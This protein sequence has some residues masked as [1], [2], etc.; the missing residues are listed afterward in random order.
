M[1]LTDLNLI[2]TWAVAVAQAIDATGLDSKAVF[3]QA[4]IDLASARDSSTRIPSDR[5]T[6]VY[7]L[8]EEVTD[9]P[10]FGLAIAEHIH[11]TS[12]H[13]LGY[14][15]FASRTLESFCRRIVRY[16]RLVTT[17]AE[18]ELQQT[19]NAYRLV[20]VP[21]VGR[22]AY[23]PQDAWLATV[24]RFTRETY[25]HDFAPRRVELR[26]PEPSKNIEKFTEFF[27]APIDFGSEANVLEIATEDMHAQLPAANPELAR[28]NDQLVLE[29]LARLDRDDIITQVRSELV[30]LLPSGDCTKE[31]V[32]AHLNM[33]ER[34]LQ[35]RLMDKGTSYRELLAEMRKELA[36]QYI[37][38]GLH[39]VSDVAYLLGFSEISSF[40][41]A[42]RTWTGVSAS[43][44]RYRYLSER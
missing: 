36:E 24:V 10:A 41:R 40:S 2:G 38:Q 14:S 19:E 27:Q 6:R 42:F 9:D 31:R 35:N 25:R 11:P 7:E 22:M 17:N 34:T 23:A 1:A 3:E 5:M 29:L 44:Y 28:Q 21:T 32:A 33:S 30:E 15:L 8:A 37:R 20:M 12:L 4:G 39:S 13:A 16:F 26:R 18:T 43:E